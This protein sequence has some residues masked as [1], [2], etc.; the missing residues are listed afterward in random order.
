MRGLGGASKPCSWLAVES[1]SQ[2]AF[3]AVRLELV[4]VVALT[5]WRRILACFWM[6]GRGHCA[7]RDRGVRGWWWAHSTVATD[8]FK[9]FENPSGPAGW[10]S[11]S[12]AWP[13]C[14]PVVWSVERT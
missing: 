11:D 13:R 12:V 4:S 2:W 6:A 14:V 1:L 8:F 3:W 7:G 9:A 10:E 5:G